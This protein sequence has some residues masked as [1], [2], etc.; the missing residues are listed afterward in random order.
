MKHRP[1]IMIAPLLLAL[2]F[3]CIAPTVGYA[4]DP[5]AEGNT[6]DPPAGGDTEETPPPTEDP[7]VVP[8]EQ[9]EPV[10]E[11]PWIT[12]LDVS[13]FFSG[14]TLTLQISGATSLPDGALIDFGVKRQG[15][16]ADNLFLCTR[17]QNKRFETQLMLGQKVLPGYYVVTGAFSPDRQED[18]IRTEL[19]GVSNVNAIFPLV[20]GKPEDIDKL[21]ETSLDSYKESVDFVAQS[22]DAIKKKYLELVELGDTF[23]AG[24]RWNAEF[25]KLPGEIAK[26][27]NT[28]ENLKQLYLLPPLPMVH[29]F[30]V[31]GLCLLDSVFSELTS[32]LTAEITADMVAKGWTRVKFLEEAEKKIVGFL[33]G[34]AVHFAMERNAAFRDLLVHQLNRLFWFLENSRDVF[35]VLSKGEPGKGSEYWTSLMTKWDPELTELDKA[36]DQHR[37][38]ELAKDYPELSR[39]LQEAPKA[40]REFWKLCGLVLVD[41]AP[42]NKHIDAI[43]NAYL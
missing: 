11:K 43:N 13:S 23:E 10:F 32:G 28:L 26:R 20:I 35:D 31:E 15:F 8:A 42:L 12:L 7:D 33:K 19:A 40:L 22:F 5:S 14:D 25:E 38:S 39:A 17:S 4:Q 37:R 1:E 2:L 30:V 18:P 6:E 24:R 3:F 27:R 41:G 36:L 21:R 34:M 29:Y 16:A 9:P